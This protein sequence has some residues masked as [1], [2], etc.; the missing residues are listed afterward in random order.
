M[1]WNLQKFDREKNVN[2]IKELRLL[3]D[4]L[5]KSIISIIELARTELGGFSKF[6]Y[7]DIHSGAYVSSHVATLLGLESNLKLQSIETSSD[8]MSSI[9]QLSYLKL[10]SFS[11]IYDIHTN[12]VS[13]LYNFIREIIPVGGISDRGTWIAPYDLYGQII[14]G[15][16]IIT[17]DGFHFT[18]KGKECNYVLAQDIENGNI[19]ILLQYTS[20]GEFKSLHFIDKKHHI[21]IEQNIVKYNEK[22]SELPIHIDS[23]HVWKTWHSITIL[24]EYG[25]EV[26]CSNDINICQI[27]INGFYGNKIRGLM[28]NGNNEPFDDTM[29]P[30]MKISS[31]IG[32]FGNAYRLQKTCALINTA[33]SRNHVYMKGNATKNRICADLFSSTSLSLCNW[34]VDNKIYHE[35]CENAVEA[36]SDYESKT[37]EACKIVIGYVNRCH[38]SNIFIPIPNQCWKCSTEQSKENYQVSLPNKKADIIILAELSITEAVLNEIISAFTID[39]RTQ[40]KA[41][42]LSDIIVNVVGYDDNKQ[43]LMHFTSIGGGLDYNSKFHLNLAKVTNIP[44]YEP[45]L[46]TGIKRLDEL[47]EIID[48]GQKYLRSDYGLSSDANAF[49]YAL[50]YPYRSEAERTIIAIRNSSLTYSSN[51]IKLVNAAIASKI[52]ENLGINVHLITPLKLEGKN[53][54]QVIGFNKRV[55]IQMSDGKKRTNIGSTDVRGQLKYNTDLGIE[56]TDGYIVSLDNYVQYKIAS[57]ER[58]QFLTILLNAIA[59]QMARNEY[60]FDC[61]CILT[62]QNLWPQ[63]VCTVKKFNFGPPIVSIK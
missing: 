36:V 42:G 1:F 43:Y 6:I 10:F 27:K 20:D 16:H 19:T 8:I 30:N 60:D 25:F 47:F 39:M 40:L 23:I 57:K 33:T 7:G 35:T 12:M 26:I 22:P 55:A 14:S 2:D 11:P 58:K 59:D 34:L 24:S 31:D 29:L 21:E 49:R 51:P 46:K 28:G 15:K 61:K 9:R 54:K 53:A 32:E 5:L 63:D 3:Y 48:K 38:L 52:A 50:S 13:N 41:R 62:H 4:L 56:H 18:F 37:V 45:A 44:N 17:F